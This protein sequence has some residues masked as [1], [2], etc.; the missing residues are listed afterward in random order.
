MHVSVK[1]RPP[2]RAIAGFTLI[3]LVAVMVIMATLGMFALPNFSHNDATVPA[4][5]D[6]LG[7]VLRHAQALAMSQGRSLTVDIQ[8]TTGY[9]ITDGTTSTA[10][11]DPS[12]EE[13]DY[14][15]ENGV[16]LTGNDIEFD[17]LGR[18]INTGSLISSAQTWTLNGTSNT[19]TVSLQPLTGF[20]TVSP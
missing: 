3:E 1:T 15:L 19:A 20:V 16:T 4:Q 13:Q 18:P 6:Q 2:H 5:A 7:R 12:G 11:Y 14:I 10:I 8:S 9:A 17:S